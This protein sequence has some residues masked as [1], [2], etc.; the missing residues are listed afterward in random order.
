MIS[1]SFFVQQ[2]VPLV[3]NDMRLAEKR[4]YHKI[5]DERRIKLLQMVRLLGINTYQISEE[6]LTLKAASKKL[7]IN[8]S[9]AKTIMQTLKHKGRILKKH[10]RDRKKRVFIE[11]PCSHPSQKKIKMPLPSVFP[12]EANT[13][14]GKLNN[15]ITK[16]YWATSKNKQPQL[17]L[18]DGLNAEFYCGQ[19]TQQIISSFMERYNP[20]MEQIKQRVRTMTLP[21]PLK[22]YS[23]SPQRCRQ[24]KSLDSVNFSD[25]QQHTFY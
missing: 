13:C 4:P 9:S 20:M 22:L 23:Y 18:T 3:G 17:N 24:N 10:T 1:Q 25:S 8:Y 16:K 7:K 15:D 6:K 11:N 12:C 14:S 21:I 2:Q 19:Y 5:D